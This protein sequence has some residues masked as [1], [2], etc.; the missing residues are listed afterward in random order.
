M[1]S[2]W[3]ELIRGRVK[4]KNEFVSADAARTFKEAPGTYEM[5]SRER[6]NP[7]GKDPQAFAFGTVTPMSPATT[8]AKSGRETPDYF[9]RE[10]RY[11]S[12]TRSFSSPK[13]PHASV[14][15]WDSTAS[16]AAPK[17]FYTGMDPLSMNKI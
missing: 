12:P 1:F 8:H 3:Y 2:G 10:A 7:S 13:P 9:G 14:Q 17:P 15:S 4:P 6:D 5:L 16:H 11:K